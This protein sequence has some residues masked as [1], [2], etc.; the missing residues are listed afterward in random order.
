MSDDERESPKFGA[1]A[2]PAAG[3]LGSKEIAQAL[4]ALPDS[5]IRPVEE[6]GMPGNLTQS[7][8]LA[9]KSESYESVLARYASRGGPVQEQEPAMER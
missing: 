9:T 8:V 7:E 1:G 5:N 6:P 3:R 2:L 4:V